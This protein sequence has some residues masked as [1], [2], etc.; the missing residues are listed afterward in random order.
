VQ[1]VARDL[2]ILSLIER[3]RK[4]QQRQ[5]L[6][7]KDGRTLGGKKKEPNENGGGD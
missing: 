4:H 7:E 6:H 5:T 1:R 3:G 2:G